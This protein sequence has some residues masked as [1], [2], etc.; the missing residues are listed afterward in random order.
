MTKHII[1][2]Y[3]LIDG[4]RCSV[5]RTWGCNLISWNT[6]GMELMYCPPEL[7]ESAAKITG[8][9]NPILFPAVGRT[10]D[11]S[12]DKPILGP[13][14]I[15]GSEH[16][17]HMPNHGIVFKSHFE[18]T[19]LMETPFLVTS[20]YDICIPEEVHQESYP[21][22]V[23]LTQS[24]TLKPDRIDLWA[25]ITNADTK[26]APVAFGYHPYFRVSNPERKGVEIK[27]PATKEVILT[28]DTILPTGEM[29]DFDGVLKLAPGVYYD[30]LY[31]GLVGRRM[32]LWDKQA[33]RVV[34]VDFD[35]NT[36]FLVVYAPDNSDFV[37]IEPWTRGLG[38]FMELGRSD[39]EKTNT[40][41]ILQ[42]GETVFF[43]VTF[44]V[45]F[46]H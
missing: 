11:L 12:G 45:E 21:F 41:K 1:D 5:A 20:V 28:P 2:E 18:R 34:H 39:W 16:R 27:L 46:V 7:P 10:W 24:F 9:G 13:Y 31:T 25:R 43:S 36:E 35:Q 42:P 29:K 8:G 33:G 15:Y 40:I 22:D 3:Q 30:N 19:G 17:Y 23:R 14:R 44:S 4:S 26:P 37:C 32:S 6:R 38:A